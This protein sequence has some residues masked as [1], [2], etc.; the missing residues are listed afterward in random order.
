MF[1]LIRKAQTGQLPGSEVPCRV[2]N[3]TDDA[4]MPGLADALQ[5]L[6]MAKMMHRCQDLL[7]LGVSTLWNA[8]IGQLPGSEVIC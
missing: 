1:H 5:L 4:L 6:K 7:K 2:E 8:Q 3:G